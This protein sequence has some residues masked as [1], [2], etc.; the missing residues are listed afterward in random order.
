M[1]LRQTLRLLWLPVALSTVVVAALASWAWLPGSGDLLEPEERAWLESQK[2]ILGF[3]PDSPPI[4]FRDEH[5]RFSG[6]VADYVELVEEKLDY[7]FAISTADSW[8]EVLERAQAG[9]I[10]L[11]PAVVRTPQRAE[12]LLFTGPYLRSPSVILTQANSER[13]QRLADLAGVRT[14]VVR[15][16]AIE[17][18]LRTRHPEIEVVTVDDAT[19]GL[20]DLSLG[21][22]DAM[23][24]VLAIAAPLI[25]SEGL[26][27]LRVAGY[28]GR[29][30]ELRMGSANDLP[31][32]HRALSRAVDAITQD[33]RNAILARWIPIERPSVF[34][35]WRLWGTVAGSVLLMG[36]LLVA[37]IVW[38]RALNRRVAERTQQL[39][40]EFAAR[41]KAEAALDDRE[42]SLV[43]T[44]DSIADPIVVTDAEGRIVRMNRP[45]AALAGCTV[46]EALGR[47][48][49]DVFRLVDPDT[50]EPVGSGLE[51]ALAAPEAVGFG[52]VA[53]LITG[54]QERRV[55]E[56]CVAIRSRGGE[57]IGAVLALRDVTDQHA[58]REQL[59]ES[60]RLEAVRQ[61]A[62][63]LA[64]DFNNVLAAIL[65]NAELLRVD[66]GEDSARRFAL[67]EIV[68]AS[69]RG[70]RFTQQ[71][72]LFAREGAVESERV[73]VAELIEEALAKAD[74][75][76]RIQV[77]HEL[78]AEESVFECSRPQLLAALRAVIDNAVDAM[79]AGGT[80]RV[81]T[82]NRIPDRAQLLQQSGPDPS[83]YLEVAISDTGR[84]MTREESK[85]VF[86]PFFTTKRHPN[87]A[88]LGL[89][90]AYGSVRNHGGTIRVESEPGEGTT[91]RIQLPLE[92]SRKPLPVRAKPEPGVG[93]ILVVDDDEGVR[94][95]CSRLLESIGYSV[96]ACSDGAQALDFFA[97]HHRDLALV[98]LDLAMPRIGGEGVLERIREINGSVP[99]VIVSGYV[100][101]SRA[102]RLIDHGAV[103]LLWKP[104]SLSELAHT[105]EQH[106]TRSADA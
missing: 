3:D 18:E 23:V 93:R 38:N 6:I 22:V 29:D 94:A 100:Q 52:N 91:F 44:L 72:L 71:L 35:S 51:V 92:L 25:E 105:V 103:G 64:H 33:E 57:T 106:V 27:N 46:A 31:I 58:L 32:L 50:R 82:C 78:E 99:V 34:T 24:T 43:S 10:Q 5:G 12:F 59:R 41:E 53:L 49:R 60:N 101:S 69:Q 86:E 7:R 89:A 55:S 1:N 40:R 19:V 11:L 84:G 102:R 28:T 74:I 95:L 37:V 20:T 17:S 14:A 80:L 63:G 68:K 76:P 4:E 75:P 104:F 98:L 81:S 15:G 36:V 42:R 67:D 85:R 16:S 21:R 90:S 54:D 61:L 65:G 56:T 8:A 79:P 30:L 2:I 26:T 62:A 39:E 47:P 87:S 77:V 66:L 13:G 48:M 96:A 45:C 70:S 9:R 97:K 73:D 88:G 83:R